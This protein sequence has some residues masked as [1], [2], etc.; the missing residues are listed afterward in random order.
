MADKSAKEMLAEFLTGI[1]DA[2]R[3]V[4]GSVAKIPA[5]NFKPR[6]EALT[7]SGGGGG[8]V[9]KPVLVPLEV[10]A[11][12]IY[13][14]G[15]GV[16]GF[17]Q[18]TVN[19]EAGETLTNGIAVHEVDANGN[20]LD[21]TIYGEFPAVFFKG[22]T[23]L[24]KAVL[25]DTTVINESSFD[26]C[27]SLAE[28]VLPSTLTTI[29][30]YAFRGCTPLKSVTI[31][32]S[33]TSVGAYAFRNCTNLEEIYWNAPGI[34]SVGS[35]TNPVFN[36]CTAL[37]TVRFGENV[38]SIPD[39][40]FKGCTSPIGDIVLPGGVKRIG[41]SAFNGCTGLTS[42]NI[43]AG[44]T[45][46]GN[47]AFLNCTSLASV[48]WNATSISSVGGSVYPIFEGCSALTNFVIGENVTAL[49]QYMLRECTGIVSIVIPNSVTTIGQQAL[50]GCTA[51]VSVQIGT[52]V[53]CA[54]ATIGSNAFGND[55]ALTDITIYAEADAVS[56][57]PWGASSVDI[58]TWAS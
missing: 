20:W 23:Y 2:I 42:V 21:V 31:P 13:L 48:V 54:I 28:I 58:I 37:S 3:K 6:I 56:G 43:P 4:D 11:N 47:S 33:V 22:N 30:R 18:I 41:A 29:G 24:K 14:P 17:N 15:E 32:A 12:G 39:Y 34:S 27:T 16:D 5:S 57:S 9:V 1:A 19:V 40:I 35:S 50:Y 49:P 45:S 38:T 26:G 53:A 51:L 25:V 36:G 7:G 46:I 44:V 55:T 8:E 10:T 52:S